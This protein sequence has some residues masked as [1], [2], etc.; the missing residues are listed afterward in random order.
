MAG[1]TPGTILGCYSA[2]TTTSRVVLDITPGVAP[3]PAA[4]EQCSQGDAE[5]P[6]DDVEALECHFAYFFS[7]DLAQALHVRQIDVVR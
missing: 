6:E 1:F 5:E 7:A 2:T 3:Y 4:V